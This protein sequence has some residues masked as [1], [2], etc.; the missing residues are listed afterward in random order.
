MILAYLKISPSSAM[1]KRIRVTVVRVHRVTEAI[2]K[3]MAAIMIYIGMMRSISLSEL[4]SPVLFD[5]V[6]LK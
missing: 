1:T 6:Y 4:G 5:I 2:T 3:S